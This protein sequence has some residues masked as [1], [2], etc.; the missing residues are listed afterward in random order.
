M[1]DWITT[2]EGAQLT[3]YT[4]DYVRHLVRTG[5]VK[6][7]LWGRSWMVSR[8]ALVAHQRRAAK[9]GEKRGPKTEG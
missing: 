6:G 5:S 3:G 1:S 9:Q 8:A 7:Q 2:A 4:V